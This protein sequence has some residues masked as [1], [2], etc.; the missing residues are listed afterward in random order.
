M[1][2]LVVIIIL[3]L[4]LF[5]FLNK[6]KIVV[7]RI[8]STNM[9]SNRN[10]E[11][12]YKYILLKSY[13]GGTD[14]EIQNSKS[15]SIEEAVDSLVKQT[16]GGEFLKNVKV[17]Q[18]D[19]TYFAVEGDVWGTESISFR[20]FSIGQKIAWPNI[21]GAIKFGTIIGLKDD[22]SCIVQSNAD[23]EEPIELEYKNLTLVN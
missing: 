5:L 1:E 9:I 12:N 13:V 22:K 8:G 16:P 11:S 2:G 10:V 14:K 6:K 4:I 7:K 21:R 17:Y 19:N 15:K 3:A 18:I 20:G 23:S